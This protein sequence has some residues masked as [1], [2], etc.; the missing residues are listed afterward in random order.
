MTFVCYVETSNQ[1]VPHMEP[2][3]ASSRDDALREAQ[4]ILDLHFGGLAV[5]VYEGDTLV[6]SFLRGQSVR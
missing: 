5:E 6:G 4:R 3:M 2:I 1:T